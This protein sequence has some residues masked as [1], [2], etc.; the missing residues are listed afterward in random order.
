MQGQLAESGTHEE[1]LAQ[2]GLYFEL[3]ELQKIQEN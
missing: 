1:L 2:K 3:A